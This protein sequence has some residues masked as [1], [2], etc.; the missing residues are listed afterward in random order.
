MAGGAAGTAAVA[1][2]AGPHAG[3][4]RL[5][6]EDGCIL[7]ATAHGKPISFTAVM[8]SRNVLLSVDIPDVARLDQLLVSLTV[9]KAEASSRRD[10][11]KEE[12]ALDTRPTDALAS[13]EGEER[14]RLGVAVSPVLRQG[15]PAPRTRRSDQ[16]RVDRR[17]LCVT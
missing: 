5:R 9:A 8:S 10:A 1:L 11:A 15:N 12:Y 14:R 3:T 7:A 16:A 13:Y 6:D 17:I 4:Y 2:V